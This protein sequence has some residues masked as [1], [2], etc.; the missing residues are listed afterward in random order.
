MTCQNYLPKNQM[1]RR[2]FRLSTQILRRFVGFYSLSGDVRRTQML[3]KPH[4]GRPRSIQ[5]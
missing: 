1:L 5:C 4:W 2:F 3:S